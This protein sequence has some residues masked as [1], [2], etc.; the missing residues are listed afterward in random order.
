MNITAFISAT[1][2]EE[3]KAIRAGDDELVKQLNELKQN[4]YVSY[5]AKGI[6]KMTEHAKN[7]VE[8][9]YFREFLT[10]YAQNMKQICG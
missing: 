1:L 8:S 10:Y 2:K 6:V 5:L 3:I 4:M 7:K 9:V